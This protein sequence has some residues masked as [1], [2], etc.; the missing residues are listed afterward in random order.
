MHNIFLD[1]ISDTINILAGEVNFDV[2]STDENT[3]NGYD[4][5]IFPWSIKVQVENIVDE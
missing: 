1:C 4:I 5:L 2:V 3:A